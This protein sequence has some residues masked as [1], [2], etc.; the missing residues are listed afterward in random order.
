MKSDTHVSCLR[1]VGLQVNVTYSKHGSDLSLF[2]VNERYWLSVVAFE[3]D[4]VVIL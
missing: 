2:T 1:H 4:A 3:W